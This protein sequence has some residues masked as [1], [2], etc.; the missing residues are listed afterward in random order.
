MPVNFVAKITLLIT[1]I[2]SVLFPQDVAVKI[3]SVTLLSF[4][5]YVAI[6]RDC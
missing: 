5:A 3:I 2:V 4:T 1:T 6:F